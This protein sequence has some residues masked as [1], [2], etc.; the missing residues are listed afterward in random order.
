MHFHNH[1]IQIYY[2]LDELFS[3]DTIDNIF[4]TNNCFINKHSKHVLPKLII[5]K[6][7]FPEVFKDK[8]LKLIIY[9]NIDPDIIC[10]M[11][12]NE[13]IEIKN[14]LSKLLLT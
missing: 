3:N 10:D 14:K 6:K 4:I 1:Q 7:T 8:F 12:Q 5:L 11:Y 9:S 13:K 2:Y